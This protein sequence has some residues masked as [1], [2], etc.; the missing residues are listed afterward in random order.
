VT[1]VADL[2]HADCRKPAVPVLRSILLISVG[3]VFVTAAG[4]ARGQ[5][6]SDSDAAPANSR[7][8]AQELFALG[9]LQVDLDELDAAEA[10]YLGGIELLIE[11]DGEFSPRLLEPYRELARVYVQL[12]QHLEA[13]TVL[14]HAQHISQRNFGLFNTDQ[15]TIIDEMS[16]AYQAA[17]DTRSAQEIKEETLNIARRRFGEDSLEIVPFHYHLA[18]YYELSRMREKARDHYEDAVDIL[19]EHLDEYAVELLRPLRELVRIDILTGKRSFARRRLEEMLE[20]DAAFSALERARSLAVLGDWS[21]ATGREEP[22]LAHYRAAYATLATV[23]AAAATALFAT[24]ALINFVPPAG[25]VDRAA[26]ISSYEWGSITAVFEIS[27][28]GRASSVEIVAA[29][30]PGLMNARYGRRLMESYFR[31]RLV[32]GE[33]V[34]TTQ[35]RFTH[36]FRYFPL[37]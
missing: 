21:L 5:Q 6:P 18:E 10:S 12:G 19:E 16:Q 34:A 11:E 13:L 26:G 25:P 9:A 14:E 15:T 17:G 29:T 32:A 27:A 30:P 36:R 23:D 8:D 3:L 28:N 20:L 1:S 31:P 7:D 2:Q 37:E 35:V 22:G 24:P 4:F 33:P